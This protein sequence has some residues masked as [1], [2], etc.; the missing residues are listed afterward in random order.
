MFLG[1]RNM[2]PMLGL[3][4]VAP[5]VEADLTGVLPI[6]RSQRLVAQTKHSGTPSGSNANYKGEML[7]I[8]AKFPTDDRVEPGLNLRVRDKRLGAAPV[9]GVATLTPLPGAKGGGPTKEELEAENDAWAFMG[10]KMG[11]EGTISSASIA[12][13][14][15]ELTGTDD[16]NKPAKKV[17]VKADDDDEEEIDP[18]ALLAAA[19]AAAGGDE[20]SDPHGMGATPAYLVGREILPGPLEDALGRPPFITAPVYR[21]GF[22]K[23]EKEVVGEVKFCLRKVPLAP[24]A[25][26]G[27]IEAFEAEQQGLYNRMDHLCSD[28]PFDDLVAKCARAAGPVCAAFFWWPRGS[29]GRGQS[30]P[31]PSFPF[32]PPR[33]PHGLKSDTPRPAPSQDL[34]PRAPN[35]ARVRPPRH[36]PQ[37]VEQQGHGKPLR[38]LPAGEQDDGRVEGRDQRDPLPA[39][40]QDVRVPP[41][42][43]WVRAARS[44]LRR[45]AEPPRTPG[46]PVARGALLSSRLPPPPRHTLP[47]PQRLHA[48]REG[49]RAGPEH[50]RRRRRRRAHRGDRGARNALYPSCT[51]HAPTV[52]PIVTPT[53]HP[54][55]HPPRWTW[56]TGGSR[57]CGSASTRSCRPLRSAS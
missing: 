37:A 18:V 16:G 28:V 5:A 43:P 47:P 12:D 48:P 39:L 49:V 38:G 14:L 50:H 3:P 9:V 42:L 8:R 52:A 4:I 11:S 1:V 46:S 23:E 26:P 55:L 25:I 30:R 51:H 17:E 19:N 53:A 29:P 31:A 45:G 56:R 36:R 44:L 13:G 32:I 7:H 57:T 27:K 15:S 24:A 40:L 22:G 6:L 10:K 34:R 21:I 2:I 20:A 54:P 41:A 33:T 35:R